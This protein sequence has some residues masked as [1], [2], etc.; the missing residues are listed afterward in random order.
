MKSIGFTHFEAAGRRYPIDPAAVVMRWCGLRG[1][2][3]W[4]LRRVHAICTLM[5]LSAV[6]HV[7]AVQAEAIWQFVDRDGVVHMGNA[8]PPQSRGLVWIG[9]LPLARAGQ[10][11]ERGVGALRLPGYKDAKPHLE[12]AALSAAIDPALVI[13]VAAAESAFNTEAVS[14]KG[15]L[16]LMQVMPATAERYGVAAHSTAEGRRAMMEPKVNA[17]IGSRYLADLLR[18]FDGDKELAL[19]AYNAG[20]GAVMKYG[21]R[22]PPY[23]ETQQY[24]ERVMRFYRTLAR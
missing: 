15:A 4:T 16:G 8:A 22:I 17:Q 23:P 1:M 19:A 21:K 6:F 11:P 2:L 13:A 5:L 9:Q 24:V 12:A 18:L 7:G 10:A 3:R 20:E 14:R